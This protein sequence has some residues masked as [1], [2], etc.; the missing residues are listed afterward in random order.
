MSCLSPWFYCNRVLLHQNRSSSDLDEPKE[1]QKERGVERGGCE[2][3]P[4]SH[5]FVLPDSKDALALAVVLL[6]NPMDL[7]GHSFKA[8]QSRANKE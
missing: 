6:L 7:T 8:A 1:L 4:R 3:S 2:A 5:T